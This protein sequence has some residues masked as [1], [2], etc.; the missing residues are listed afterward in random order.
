M[1]QLAIKLVIFV[2]VP[3]NNKSTSRPVSNVANCKAVLVDY[4]SHAEML[5]SA[6]A[7]IALEIAASTNIATPT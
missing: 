3:G 6:E 5:H 1:P 7:S 2:N 4:I